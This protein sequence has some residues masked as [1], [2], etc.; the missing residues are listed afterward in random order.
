MQQASWE[1]CRAWIEAALKTCPT[2]GIEDVEAGIKSGAFQCWAGPNC[3]AV[4]EICVFPKGKMLHHWL[5]GGDLRELLLQVRELESWAKA[6]GCVAIYGSS[7]D[8]PAFRRV[9]D[10]NGWVRGQIEYQKDLT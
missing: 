10:R 5:S 6:Q 9:M 4:T 8:R 1:R 3:V 2:H 7:A